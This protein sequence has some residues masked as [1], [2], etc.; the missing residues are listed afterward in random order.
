MDATFGEQRVLE[1]ILSVAFLQRV[2]QVHKGEVT[3]PSLEPDI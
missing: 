3:C 1:F 2:T